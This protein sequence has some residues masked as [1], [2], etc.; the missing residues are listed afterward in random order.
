MI[1]FRAMLDVKVYQKRYIYPKID[2]YG[3][4][5]D[6]PDHEAHQST[7]IDDIYQ[8][9]LNDVYDFAVNHSFRFTSWFNDSDEITIMLLTK[10]FGKSI[11]IYT[12]NKNII[13]TDGHTS[14]EDIVEWVM[15]TSVR[16]KLD[17]CFERIVEG[18][19]AIS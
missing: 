9:L 5:I 17:K 6:I 1:K 15:L 10:R 7:P 3:K 16:E 18:G 13:I 8:I 12:D 11:F 19:Y 4:V 2:R 14:S